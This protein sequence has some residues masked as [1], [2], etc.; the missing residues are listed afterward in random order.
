M[1]R[2]KDRAN[3]LLCKSINIIWLLA[4]GIVV[5]YPFRAVN[6]LMQH[7]LPYGE[8]QSLRSTTLR[9]LYQ[10]WLENFKNL[11]LPP[12]IILTIYKLKHKDEVDMWR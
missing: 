5:K 4:F 12:S 10:G 9:A 7:L 3:S 1:L 6:S 11:Y 8:T 2:S